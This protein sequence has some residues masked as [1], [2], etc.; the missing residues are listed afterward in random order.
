MLA[1]EAAKTELSMVEHVS[2]G[3]PKHLILIRIH[4]LRSQKLVLTETIVEIQMD[5]LQ[6]GATLQIQTKDGK[7]VNHLSRNSDLKDVQERI[8]L[9]TEAAKT[10]L[11]EILYVSHGRHKKLT[12]SLTTQM[13]VWNKTIVEIQMDHLQ[14]G[15]TLKMVQDKIASQ[16][17]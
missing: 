13:P 10:K 11:S 8:V 9:D 1:T 4:N 5:Q 17:C 15:A 14:F 2:H 3:M 12:H 7:T 6:F 16:S